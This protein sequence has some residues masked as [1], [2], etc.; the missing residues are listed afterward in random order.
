MSGS[1]SSTQR[2]PP[3]V[4][5]EKSKS[6][7][8]GIVYLGHIPDGLNPKSIRLLLGKFGEI[9]RIYLELDKS[10]KKNSKSSKKSRYVE[11]WVEFKK[12]SIAK[13][14]A[15]TLNGTTIGGKR[16]TRF[17]GALWNL[18]YLKRFKWSHLTEQM[19]YE[20]A[21]VDQKLR[22]EMRL[23]KKEA[24][25]QA[26]MIERSRKKKQIFADPDRSYKQR[27]TDEQILAEKEDDGLDD[28]LM[29]DI[30]K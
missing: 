1:E 25:F 7:K 16:R 15:A 21:L 18:K 19:N 24:T 27:A 28:Q 11:G 8:R 6:C 5:T 12:K 30:F 22:I 14:V 23:A 26:Q 13:M 4:N 3:I 29:A 9:D 17:Y 10:L 2:A 20:K